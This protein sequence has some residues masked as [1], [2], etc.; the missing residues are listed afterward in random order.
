MSLS[1]KNGSF[2]TH[3]LDRDHSGSGM[4]ERDEPGSTEEHRLQRRL[5]AILAMDV[6]SYSRLMA[7]DEEAT[8]RRL[9][10]MMAGIVEPSVAAFRGRVFKRMGDGTLAEFPSVVDTIRCAVDIQRRVSA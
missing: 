7:I 5:S 2:V 10:A 6:A 9:A 4:A 1:W 3:V 8:F